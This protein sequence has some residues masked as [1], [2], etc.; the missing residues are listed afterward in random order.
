MKACILISKRAITQRQKGKILNEKRE[1]VEKNNNYTD[2]INYQNTEI[3][4]RY[5]G[6]RE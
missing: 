4:S 3:K 1:Q 2:R 6:A 5:P